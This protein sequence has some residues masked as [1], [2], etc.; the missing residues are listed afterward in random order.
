MASSSALPKLEH[1]NVHHPTQYVAHVEINRPAKLN[2]FIQGYYIPTRMRPRSC[3]LL[4][5]VTRM[6]LELR[7]IFEALSVDPGVR[8]IVLSGAGDRAFTTG[9][10]VQAA[11]AESAV[12]QPA[13]AGDSA[14]QSWL[15]RRHIIQFQDCISAIERCEKPVI[16]VLHGFCLGLAIDIASCTDVRFCSADTIFAV[17]EV[18]IGLAADVGTLSR[19]PKVVGNYGWVKDV[20]LTARRFG[21]AEA[22][23]VGFV[24]ALHADKSKTLEAATQRATLVAAK[25]PVAVQSTKELLNWSRDHTVQDG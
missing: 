4:L 8:C 3:R 1:F 25:S 14:R 16:C 17:Q 6:W 2:A 15:I 19:L 23:K 11:A 7:T 18:E 22:E 21:A 9:L 12:F 13:L 10:D 5:T 24:Q 20:C